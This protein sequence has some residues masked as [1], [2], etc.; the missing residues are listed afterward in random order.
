MGTSS[1]TTRLTQARDLAVTAIVKKI[2]EIQTMGVG[3]AFTAFAAPVTTTVTGL[4]NAAGS[5]AVL[6]VEINRLLPSGQP[7]T[8]TASAGTV[9]IPAITYTSVHS[10]VTKTTTIPQTVV[11]SSSTAIPLV[12]SVTWASD[13]S[14][15][16]IR[17]PY[18]HI[19][20]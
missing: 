6:T 18:T 3:P 8:T 14:L 19:S 15:V 16:S 20:R 2:E 4:T 9:T 13:G 7:A 12:V 1:Q 10:G 5:D 11:S 17:V